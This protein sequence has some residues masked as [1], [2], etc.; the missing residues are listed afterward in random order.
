M[1]SATL[2]AAR[3]S[4]TTS[5]PVFSGGT[6]QLLALLTSSLDLPSVGRIQRKPV[7]EYGGELVRID[8]LG[9]VSGSAC[10]DTPLALSGV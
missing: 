5:L 6:A 2:T 3:Q 7:T 10:I 4:F 9:N 1:S 8:R